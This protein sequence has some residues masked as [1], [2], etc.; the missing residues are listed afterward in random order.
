MHNLTNSINYKADIWSRKGEILKST[1]NLTK[2]C[3]I[4]KQRIYHYGDFGS[5]DRRIKQFARSHTS[6]SEDVNDIIML[7]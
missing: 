1:H 6:P 7:S 5:R 2:L 3:R 4:R